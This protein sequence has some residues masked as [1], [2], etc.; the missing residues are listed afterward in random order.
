MISGNIYLLEQGASLLAQLDDQM[1][2]TVPVEISN[3]GIGAHL[4]HCLDF[5]DSFLRGIELGKVDYDLRERNELIEI[6]R[7]AALA[8]IR[9]LVD[10]LRR[11]CLGRDLELLV[12]RENEHSFLSSA[13]DRSSIQRELQFLFSHT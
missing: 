7:G 13:W 6:N 9:E 1:Y 11:V 5:Y 4:R 3:S 12:K 2:A 8:K 10:R